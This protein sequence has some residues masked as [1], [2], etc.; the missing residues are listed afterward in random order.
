VVG[1]PVV[2]QQSPPVFIERDPLPQSSP[3]PVTPPPP[4]GWW[5]FC[6][7]VNAYYPYIR[8]CPGGWQRVSPQP[9]S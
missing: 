2:I 1:P 4:T 6:P 3:A 5:Y 7:G 8:E 9:P